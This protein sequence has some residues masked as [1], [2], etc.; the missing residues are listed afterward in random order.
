MSKR[1]LAAIGGLA[2]VLAAALAVFLYYRARTE[3][4]SAA[5][6][7]GAAL[8]AALAAAVDGAG[9]IAAPHRCARLTEPKES[10]V[11]PQTLSLLEARGMTLDGRTLRLGRSGSG[12]L[13]VGVVADARG[14]D[15]K[16]IAEQAARI[17]K[18]LKAGKVELLISLGGMGE[19]RGEIISALEPLASGA[20]WPVLALPG[21]REPLEEHRAAIAE[22]DQKPDTL[23]LD[24]S[25]IRF[26]ATGDVILGT[27]PGAAHARR[28]LAGAEGCQY[29]AEDADA[30]AEAL[31]QH[32]ETRVVVT[33]A[34]P[35][36][37]GSH[38]SDLA[39]GGV[40]IG[41]RE[42]APA[43]AASQP[44]LVVHGLLDEVAAR[45]RPGKRRLPVAHPI[46]LACGAMDLVPVEIPRQS[47]INGAALVVT[48]GAREIRWRPILF[49]G[50]RTKFSLR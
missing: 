22:L 46:Y 43:I 49:Q 48:I 40:H 6:R 26:V 29:A 3:R 11:S 7:S 24:G 10:L 23:V 34:P 8:A 36:Q 14:G 19:T 30:L 16:L 9:E 12:R 25:R 17:R 4:Q 15:A 37:T 1:R 5:N 41:A 27:L 38:A 44:S 47:S 39:A 32:E 33:H 21:D 45:Q 35:R 20:P 28:L 50:N 13:V 18:Q 2:A 31:L 42:L